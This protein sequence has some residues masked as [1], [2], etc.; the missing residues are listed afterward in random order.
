MRY[1][2]T[3]GRAPERG[4]ADILLSGLADDGGLY[5]PAHYPQVARAEL[6]SWRALS[7]AE[8]A[9]EIIAKFATD[10]PREVLARLCH[11]TYSASVY[12]NGRADSR[13][14]D[15]APLLFPATPS[16]QRK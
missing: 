1:V 6:E 9:T 5:V 13:I 8:L 16:G 3:R 7:Y 11:A 14:E 12:G 10:L 2:S 15:I 4:F